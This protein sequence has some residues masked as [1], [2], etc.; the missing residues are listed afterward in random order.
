MVINYL[1]FYYLFCQIIQILLAVVGCKTIKIWQS[2][3]P[4]K[5]IATLNEYQSF[6]VLA[7]AFLPNSNIV[8]D[9]S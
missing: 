4:Y 8:T 5:C 1:F 7:L 9:W 2:E 6:G 3:S